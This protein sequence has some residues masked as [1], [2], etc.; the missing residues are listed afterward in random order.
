MNSE[1]IA[2]HGW[3]TAIQVTLLLALGLTVTALVKYK[4]A[5]WQTNV[6]RSTL[7]ASLALMCFGSMFHRTSNAAW[8]I[9]TPAVGPIVQFPSASSAKHMHRAERVEAAPTTS[10][11]NGA[12]VTRTIPSSGHTPVSINAGVSRAAATTVSVRDMVILLWIAGVAVGSMWVFVGMGSLL[13][14]RYGKSGQFDASCVVLVQELSNQIGVPVP[15]IIVSPK[16][17]SPFVSGIFKPTVFLPETWQRQYDEDQLHAILAHELIH[18]RNRDCLWG[19][20]A[21]LACVFAWP[22]PLVWILQRKLHAA[23]EELCDQVV[24]TTGFKATNYADC[25]VKIAELATPSRLE[26][27]IGVGV[28]PIRSTLG[29]RITLVL[30]S[31]RNT[32]TRVSLVGRIAIAGSVC[33]AVAGIGFAIAPR[34]DAG[35]RRA[36]AQLGDPNAMAFL[37][38]V[39]DAYGQL[40]SLSASITIQST[41]PS[42]SRMLSLDYMRPATSKIVVMKRD[43]LVP[44]ESL[45]TEPDAIYVTS[46]FHSGEYMVLRRATNPEWDSMGSLQI[47]LSAINV[48]GPS[49]LGMLDIKAGSVGSL[50]GPGKHPWTFGPDV[51]ADGVPCVTLVSKVKQPRDGLYVNT[52]TIAIGDHLVREQKDELIRSGRAFQF[53]DQIL[54]DSCEP[55]DRSLCGHF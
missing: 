4:G 15:N 35:T 45:Y 23:S 19:S 10:N 51:S 12:V 44:A 48:R 27:L 25:L 55:P 50:V 31:S 14:L 47:G 5:A 34:R 52:W 36:T 40:S 26:R 38:K 43:Q 2:Q 21:R 22:H 41:N 49:A 17:V 39:A 33:L 9:S 29:R 42:E 28:V 20:I 6:L 37:R 24:L 11:I 18:I 32:V 8:N 53:N 13:R 1:I 16:V 30:N 3:V 7:I 46:P 54:K